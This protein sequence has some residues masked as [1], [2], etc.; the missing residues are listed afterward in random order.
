MTYSIHIREEELKNKIAQD[1]F[2]EYDTTQIIGNVDFAV[3][4]PSNI[5]SNTE[6]EFLLWA[7]AKKGIQQDLNRA[8]AQLILTIGKAKT[9]DHYLPPI[10]IGAFDAA[11]IIFIPYTEILDIFRQNDFNWNVA[12]SDHSSKEFQTVYAL[13]RSSLE[14]NSYNFSFDRDSK[15]LVRFIKKNLVV[16]KSKISKIRI[17]KTNFVHIYQKWV[18]EVK[19]TI[20]VNWKEAQKEGLLDAHFYLADLLSTETNI[21]IADKLLVLLRDKYYELFRGTDKMGLYDSK[22]AQFNDDQIAHTKFWNKYKRPPKKEYRNY[23]AERIDLLVPQDIRERKGSYFTPQKWVE[24]SQTYLEAELGENWQDEYYIWDCAAGTGN[25][26]NGLTNKYHIW[27]STIDRSDVDI[28]QERI[29]NGA[30]LLPDHIFQFDFLNDSFDLLPDS[31]KD[32]INDPE[33]R[34]RLI[35][36][37]NPPYAE[38]ANKQTVAKTGRNKKDVAVTTHIYEKYRM[39]LGIAGR[40]L[41]AQFMMRVYREI[42]SSV[43]ASFS[44]LKNLQAPNFR[45]FRASFR[46]KLGRIFLVPADTFDNVSGKFPIS[47]QIWHLDEE[48]S[49]TIAVNADVYNSKGENIG[50][51]ALCTFE[52]RKTINDWIIATR[53]KND[54]NNSIGFMSAKGCDFQNNNYLYIVNSKKQLPHPRGTIITPDNLT[55]ICVYFAVRKSI[56]HTWLNDRDQ[57]MQPYPE[58]SLD[59]EFQNDCLTFTLF[60]NNISM[61]MGTNHWIP[62]TEE[63]VNA[64]DCFSSHFMNDFIN[65]KFGSSLY[66][67]SP[68]AFSCEAS[69]VLN[70]GKYLWRYYHSQ[71][72][73]QP[74]AA[75]YDIKKFFQGVSSSKGKSKMNSH[76][77]DKLYNDL[78]ATL[79]TKLS[80]LANKLQAKIYQY[81][82]L[83]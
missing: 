48:P 57:F 4:A 35:I 65:G 15:D 32:I 59:E 43:L 26:L 67:I 23:I 68:K 46:A 73:S 83:Q 10:Y 28:I 5:T 12:P 29:R 6:T 71:A 20:D 72:D 60:S 66:G 52:G 82:F 33:K 25:L 50:I 70:A 30:K 8:V 27:A 78:I 69:D 51:K 75:L 31:L 24:L 55:A 41:F 74:N 81:G 76:S 17:S 39:S 44:K 18:A 58:W 9:F 38:A 11:K 14:A 42:P 54:I 63:D 16:G 34:K 13:V 3:A 56:T 2:S 77:D 49:G 1:Y 61:E 19:P 21:P 40:E 64:R 80:I 22:K 37:I 45:D 47:F 7:E 53:N 36:Y 62:F 79:K